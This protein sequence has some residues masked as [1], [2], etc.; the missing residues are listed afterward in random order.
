MNETPPMKIA[1]KTEYSS[2]CCC[3]EDL[4]DSAS[5]LSFAVG[6]ATYL[7]S[8]HIVKQIKRRC[9]VFTRTPTTAV[10]VPCVRIRTDKPLPCTNK[11]SARVL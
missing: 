8:G 11:H 6:A 3:F 4:E 9:E 10:V 5:V 2:V 7:S 1:R